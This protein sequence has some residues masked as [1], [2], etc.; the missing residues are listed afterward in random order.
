MSKQ[1]KPELKVIEPYDISFLEITPNDDWEGTIQRVATAIDVQLTDASKLMPFVPFK[2]F[3]RLLQ[4]EKVFL[5]GPSGSGK[6]RTIIELLRNKGTIDGR[7]FIINP[8]SV[9]GQ[10]SDRENISLLSQ[11]FSANDVVVWDNFP[12]GLIKRDLQSAFGALEIINARPVQNLWISLKPTYLEMYRGLTLGIPD[13]Y[14]CEI[15]CDLD[16]M[17]FLVRTYGTNVEQ[18]KDVYEKYVSANIDKISKILWGKQPLSLTVVDYYKALLSRIQEQQG[19]FDSSKAI[20]MAQT[21][22]PAYDYFERQ[23]EVMK[24]IEERR[25]DVEFL[26]VL[27]FCY[28]VGAIRTFEA[29]ARLQKAIFGSTAPAEPTRR[30]GT[31]VYLSGASYAMHDSAKNAVKLTSHL[32]MKIG[33]YLTEHFLEI[34]PDNSAE[35]HSLG[36]FLGRNIHFIP[37]DIEGTFIPDHIRTFM[38]RKAIF[39]RALGRGVG[40]VFESLDDMLQKSILH[41]VDTEIEFGVGLA[42]SLGERFLELDDTNRNQVLEKTYHGMLFARYFGQS[43]G[44]LYDRLSDELRLLVMSHADKNPQ[45]ADGLGMGIGYVF[46][47]LTPELRRELIRKAQES[48]E[49]SRGLGFGFGLTFTLLRGDDT[50]EMVT[51]ADRN[52]ELDTG[53]GMGLGATYS[54]LPERLKTFAIERTARDCEFA[55]GLGIYCA[56]SYRESCPKEIFALL[57]GNTEIAN[58]LGLGFGASFF[59]L[60]DHFQAE[61]ELSSKTNIKIDDGLGAGIGLVLKHLPVE[62]QEMFFAK[63]LSNNAFAAGL[64]YGIGFTWQY[65]GDVLKEKVISSANTNGEFARGFGIGLGCHMDYLIPTLLHIMSL[66]DTNSE[67]DRGLGTGAAWAWPYFGDET[68][69]TVV[70]RMNTSGDFAKG[71]GF[72]L[73]RIIRH[74]S[75]DAKEWVSVKVVEDPSFAEGFGEGIANYLWSNSDKDE[76][77]QFLGQVLNN[78]EMAKGLGAGIGFLHFFFRTELDEMSSRLSNKDSN[79]RIGLG[80]GIGKAYR[81]LTEEARAEVFRMAETDVMFSTGLGEG[82]GSIYGFLEKSQKDVIMAHA[83]GNTGFSRGLGKG[84]GLAFPFLADDVK[85]EI[86]GYAAHNEQLSRGLGVGIGQRISYLSEAVA[87]KLFEVA[88][89]NSLLAVGLGEGCGVSLSRLPPVTKEWLSSHSDTEGFAVGLGIG[90]GRMKRNVQDSIVEQADR[91]VRSNG[92]TEGLGLGIGSISVDT[93]KDEFHVVLRRIKEDHQFAVNFAFGIGSVFSLLDQ[94]RRKETLEA[95]KGDS[96]LLRSLGEGIGHRLPSIGSRIIDGVVT[97]G[98]IDLERGVA[99]GIAQSFGYLDLTAAFGVLQYAYSRPEYGWVLGEVLAERFVYFDEEKKS[100]IL[101]VIRKDS[102]F[103]RAFGRAIKKNL[104]YVSP[105]MRERISD[106]LIQYEHLSSVDEKRRNVHE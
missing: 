23:F 2:D 33:A 89:G 81:Y 42:D 92:F 12:N 47:E 36:L 19:G 60:S 66:A 67:L 86:L 70:Q 85:S 16:T 98:L 100:M 64:G 95:M 11:R 7:I 24:G 53:F 5:F 50:K 1:Q 69:G 105:Q 26:Y 51:V 65:L 31:W 49:I 102:T 25:E 71:M 43:V 84:L 6:S 101:D 54:N 44:R 41:F 15:I 104:A 97:L 76:K 77:E 80:A 88:R 103:T 96:E 94:D 79:F 73:A 63:A 38:K 52:S 83:G 87:T 9:S 20:E 93:P 106:I 61:L 48:F 40:E 29:I 13:I 3:R 75:D 57:H 18:F 46:T 17:K 22:L 34:V 62:V 72:G 37:N 10:D 78:P 14:T 59:Y 4:E 28:E 91:L 68:K 58:G 99:R 32:N 55:F 56:F 39:E 21:W 90:V 30:L 8:S 35:L 27:R 74:I 45:F 82:V